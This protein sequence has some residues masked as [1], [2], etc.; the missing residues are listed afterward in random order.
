MALQD[1]LDSI[2]ASETSNDQAIT[3]IGTDIETVVTN[4]QAL[5]GQIPTAATTAEATAL[6][7]QASAETGKLG[8]IKASLD[9]LNVS[10]APPAPPVTPVVPVTPVTPVDPTAPVD[11]TV[12]VGDTGV[13]SFSSAKKS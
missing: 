4:V 3:D 8:A 12:P 7:I 11:P 2:Q 6:A 1:D 10:V 9:A 5:L 13:A